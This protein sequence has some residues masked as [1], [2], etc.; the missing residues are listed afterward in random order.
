LQDVEALALNFDPD[1]MSTKQLQENFADCYSSIVE[2]GIIERSVTKRNDASFG[3]NYI[4]LL[5][6]VIR[7]AGQQTN[8]SF[9]NDIKIVPIPHH[10]CHAASAYYFS[11]SVNMCIADSGGNGRK[12]CDLNLES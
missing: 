3:F 1:I 11:G 8:S 2:A 12:R 10:L 4:K 9:R 6:N 5:Q 7:Y